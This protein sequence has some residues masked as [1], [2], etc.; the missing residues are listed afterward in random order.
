M[1]VQRDVELGASLPEDGSLRMV[2]KDISLAIRAA[3][4]GVGVKLV[5]VDVGKWDG[6][7]VILMNHGSVPRSWAARTSSTMI[8]HPR[9]HKNNDNDRPPFKCHCKY[10]LLRECECCCGDKEKEGRSICWIHES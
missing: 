7:N 1:Q 8:C 3:T 10:S 9:F 6:V 2:I 4:L 5:V